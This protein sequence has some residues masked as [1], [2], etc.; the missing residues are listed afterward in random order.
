MQT[1]NVSCDKVHNVIQYDGNPSEILLGG[2]G[3]GAVKFKIGI[4]GGLGPD[5][6]CVGG[7][8]AVGGVYG[9]GGGKIGRILTQTCLVH[10]S[11]SHHPLLRRGR[12][13][14]I[15]YNYITQCSYKT[16]DRIRHTL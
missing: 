1:C 6:G 11:Y 14:S 3:G 10:I 9:G 12:I 13:S 16:K 8:Q 7:L 15:L 5:G 2:G 4:Q